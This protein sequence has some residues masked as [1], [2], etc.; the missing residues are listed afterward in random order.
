MNNEG[1]LL[2][3]E[4]PDGV[5][6]TTQARKFTNLLD[7]KYLKSPNDEGVIGFVREI[8]LN[9]RELTPFERQLIQTLSLTTNLYTEIN[10][11]APMI[12]DRSFISTLLY[13]MAQGIPE[14]QLSIIESLSK[15]MWH[16]HLIELNF[17]TVVVVLTC[18]RR[19]N[20]PDNDVYESTIDWKN[21]NLLYRNNVQTLK[22]GLSVCS[23]SNSK[24]YNQFQFTPVEHIIHIELDPNWNEDRVFNQ[25]KSEMRFLFHDD[26]ERV[27]HQNIDTRHIGFDGRR[28]I[29]V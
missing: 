18:S 25:I 4:G 14:K 3:F 15:V 5:G 16:S 29:C 22:D 19:Y 24:H 7:G 20:L 17:I 9:N 27:N 12:L 11:E 1:L 26:W 10:K 6:K 2:V 28:R 13:G 8:I 23:D 21:L